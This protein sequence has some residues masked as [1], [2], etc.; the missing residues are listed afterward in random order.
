MDEMDE[1]T[2]ADILANACAAFGDH[3]FHRCTLKVA[4]STPNSTLLTGTVLDEATLDSVAANLSA[5]VPDANFDLSGVRV[6]RSD[7]PEL[8]A[9]HTNMTGFFSEPSWLAEQ[10]SQVVNGTR[11]EVLEERDHWVLVRLE[12]G[13]LGW[14]YR[15][16]MGDLPMSRP[17]SRMVS[18]PVMELHQS[19]AAD[20]PLATRVFAGTPVQAADR[21]GGWAEVNLV[22]G[23]CG[24]APSS[25]L[26]SV[27][28]PYSA[29]AQRQQLAADAFQFIGV[30]YLWGGATALG[31]DC[32]GF[33]QLMHRLAG[34]AIPRDA[35]QQYI[36]GQPVEAPYRAGDLM[37]FGGS[38]GHRAI[39]HVGISLG[40]AY[41]AEGWVMIHSGRSRNGVYVDDIQAVASL[42]DSFQ[43]ARRFLPG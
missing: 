23:V 8:L 7:D 17:P 31:I 38:G 2:L 19:P 21:E 22:G 34:V 41:D 24:F 3:R 30:P 35:D 20:S 32:S 13:Y 1:R 12:D 10:Q 28:A 16:Y 40:A 42:R 27:A 43:G 37:Y 18:V 5:A 11:L 39:S 33:A 4:G 25:D 9:V 15:P 36:A 26:R 14:V 29:E 6:L